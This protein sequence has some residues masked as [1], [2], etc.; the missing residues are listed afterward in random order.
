VGLAPLE[1]TDFNRCR[2]DVKFVEYASCFVAPVLADAAPYRAHARHGDNALLFKDN[3][4]LL[5]ILEGLHADLAAARA[6]AERAFDY[7]TTKRLAADH[8]GKRAHFYQNLLKFEPFVLETP[9]LPDCAGL[10]AHVRQATHLWHEERFE[11]A[12][13]VLDRVLE[14]HPGYQMAQLLKAKTMVSLGRAEETLRRYGD[15]RPDPVYADLLLECLVTAAQ[16]LGDKRWRDLRDRIA[17]PALRLAMDRPRGAYA[18]NRARQILEYNPFD[19]LALSQLHDR[20]KNDPA[21]ADERRALLERLHFMEPES[22]LW[23][24][25]YAQLD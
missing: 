3:H 7:A 8:V 22:E 12:D 4:E 9:T 1:D 5:A 20:L 21:A 10:I 6:L 2:S 15:F 16:E 23:P 11:E 18:V 25:L 14:M 19:Y 24:R 13:A 17:N